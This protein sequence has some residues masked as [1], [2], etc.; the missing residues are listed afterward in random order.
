VINLKDRG[1]RVDYLTKA[2]DD[3][4]LLD[5]GINVGRFAKYG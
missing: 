4:L 1:V 5:G 2:A 3:S